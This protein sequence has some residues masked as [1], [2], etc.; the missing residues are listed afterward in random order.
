MVLG[1]LFIA[2]VFGAAATTPTPTCSVVGKVTGGV[3]HFECTD[4]D[5]NV[6][7]SGQVTIPPV[8][9]I[10][11]GPTKTIKPKPVIK[12]KHITH[13][14]TKYVTRE[15][16]IFVP[17]PTK[18]VP[19]PTRIV[20]GPKVFVPGPT[21]TKTV[22]QTGP[23]V[24]VTETVTRQIRPQPSTMDDGHGFF[25]PDL[26]LFDNHMTAAD[27]GVGLL[28][29]LGLIGLA[30]AAMYAGYVI[31]YKDSERAD[32]DFMRALSEQIALRRRKH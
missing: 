16:K 30:M 22:V 2:V 9:K 8:I 3:V 19:G 28:T 11:P 13:T 12:T 24:R 26:D 32:T 18:T 10:E 15:K 4:A 31:G 23:T 29:I 27:A 1:L 7:P 25:E 5:G 21:S 6:I 14:K 20:P 17:G